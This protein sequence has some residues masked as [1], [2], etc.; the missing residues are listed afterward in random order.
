MSGQNAEE[1]LKKLRGLLRG[2]GR[3]LVAYSG[4]VDSTLLLKVARE[5]LGDGVLAVTAVSPIY[6]PQ[7]TQ[8]A[9]E[10]A[11]AFGVRHVTAAVDVLED[12][13]FFSNP[14]ERCYHCKKRVL[15]ELLEIA[16]A[17]GIEFVL[18]AGHADDRA[19]YRPGHRAVREAGVRSPLDEVGLTKAEIRELSRQMGLP[20]WDLPSA[21]CLAS[22][23]PYGER[24]TAE[25]LARVHRAEM[26]VRELGFRQVRVRSHGDLA[27]IEVEPERVHELAAQ[28]PRDKVLEALKALGFVHVTVDLRGYRTGSLNEGLGKD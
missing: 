15:G 13:Q 23:F 12:E 18:D 4:G 2:M 20:T 11:A 26:V 9:C 7:E 19:D 22:R 1:K 5:E 24:I 17:E 3:V 28:P 10:L 16:R 6:D 8:R 21:A 27:R 14:P 25:K